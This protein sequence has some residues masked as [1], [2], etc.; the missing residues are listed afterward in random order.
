MEEIAIK[1]YRELSRLSGLKE[2]TVSLTQRV[3]S[4]IEGDKRRFKQVFNNLLTNAIKYTPEK[5]KI[6]VMIGMSRKC[7]SL[8]IQTMVSESRRK[9][10]IESLKILYRQR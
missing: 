1:V 2:H 6:E 10:R 4:E 8:I 7:K 5:G 3:F 9:I